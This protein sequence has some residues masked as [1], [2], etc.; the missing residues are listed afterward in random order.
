[1]VATRMMRRR[2]TMSRTTRR[3]HLLRRRT[4][5]LVRTSSLSVLGNG[6]RR[7]NGRRLKSMSSRWA[8]RSMLVV[9][10][11][12]LGSS[13]ATC[14]RRRTRQ[15]RYEKMERMKRAQEKDEERMRIRRQANH[16]SPVHQVRINSSS[17]VTSVRTQPS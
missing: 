5:S 8:R 2:M 1:M 4:R 11:R 7:Y 3:A 16:T 12:T 6:E 15:L 13:V 17:R 9:G 10:C 14:T